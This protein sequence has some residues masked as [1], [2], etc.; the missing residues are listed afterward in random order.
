MFHN[1]NLAEVVDFKYFTPTDFGGFNRIKLKSVT[2]GKDGW[3]V[4]V[5]NERNEGRAVIIDDALSTV[6]AKP[7]YPSQPRISATPATSA[8]SILA[9]V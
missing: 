3:E 2:K 7:E 5:V 1:F 8:S 6:R 9:V 4:E